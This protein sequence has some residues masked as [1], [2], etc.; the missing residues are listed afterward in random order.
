MT[1]SSPTASALGRPLVPS[2]PSN[3]FA[4]GGFVVGTLAARLLGRSWWEALEVGEAA[5]L[6]WATARELDPDHPETAN[7]ALPV[8]ALVALTDRPP[9]PLAGFAVLSGLRVLAATVGQRPTLPDLVALAGQAGLAARRGEQ[10]SALVPGA[11]L[12]LS[13][14]RAD[15]FRA[16]TGAARI[17]GAAG[18]LPRRREG[19]GR[20]LA[21]DVLVLAALGLAGALTAP[22]AVRSR[23]DRAPLPVPGDRVRLA[24]WVAVGSLGAGLLGGQTRSLVPLGS[25]ALLVGLRQ[26]RRGA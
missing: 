3:R 14:S 22:E 24:R 26:A 20:S 18:L 17:V 2:V 8:A 15:P 16:T 25:A 13:A 7:A 5:F 11:A 12:A 9:D 23:C 10:V 21:A 4:A 19:R 6:A 1:R